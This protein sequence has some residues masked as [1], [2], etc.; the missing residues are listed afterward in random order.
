[1]T[2][3]RITQ[4]TLSFK[5]SLNKTI[6]F[7]TF[8]V[9]T[10]INPLKLGLIPT[11]GGKPSRDNLKSTY[12]LAAYLALQMGL[13]IGHLRVKEASL[14]DGRDPGLRLFSTHPSIKAS[15]LPRYLE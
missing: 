4:N 8:Y 9:G 1:M 3:V 7:P 5:V 11:S 14:H 6:N 12:C 10:F 2:I 15:L 13:G